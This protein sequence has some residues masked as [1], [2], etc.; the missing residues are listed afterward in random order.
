MKKIYIV[1]IIIVI[2]LLVTL[3]Y[4]SDNKSQ[5]E[6]NMLIGYNIVLDSIS[7]EKEWNEKNINEQFAELEYNNSIYLSSDMKI[8]V[9]YITQKIDVTNIIGYESSDNIHK[10][11]ITLYSIKNMDINHAVAVK[12]ESDENYYM[13]VN[14]LYEDDSI[15]DSV[16]FKHDKN[17]NTTT[18]VETYENNSDS[19]SSGS[20][21]IK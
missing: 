19:Y 21:P 20:E 17:T 15:I 6:N 3:T 12:F 8:N 4:K 10:K 5:N 7:N 18:I 11:Q 13:Y 16:I 2:C 1:I 14:P 9:E